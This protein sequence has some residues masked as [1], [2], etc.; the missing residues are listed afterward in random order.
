MAEEE[1]DL[2]QLKSLETFTSG[3][4]RTGRIQVVSPQ[5]RSDPSIFHFIEL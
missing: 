1:V 5:L 2:L 4:Q 3:R